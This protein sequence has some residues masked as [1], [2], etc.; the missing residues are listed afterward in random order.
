MAN[1]VNLSI[2]QELIKEAKIYALKQGKSLSALFEEYLRRL[3]KE[4]SRDDKNED[5][6]SKKT[7]VAWIDELAGSITLKD[8]RPYK[9]IIREGKWAKFNDGDIS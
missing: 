9:E 7:G 8:S 2:D 5:P 1:R 6:E 4:E 3:L